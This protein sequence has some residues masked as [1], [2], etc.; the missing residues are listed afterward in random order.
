MGSLFERYRP[1]TFDDIVGQDTA[2]AMVKRVVSR[3]WGG[4]AFW[5]TGCSGVGKTSLARVIAAHGAC[6]FGIEEIDAQSLTPARLREIEGEMRFRVLGE[7]PGRAYIVNEAH[8][9]R[10]DTIRLLL[11]ILERLP[12]HCVWVFTTTKAGE[13][14]LFEDDETGD[15]APL[16]SRC[17]EVRL[18]DNDASRQAFAAR[19][20]EIAVAEGIDGLPVTVYAKAV[21]NSAGNFRR[22]LQRIESGG[23]KD[24]AIEGLEKE[25]SMYT[26]QSAAA[27]AGR[28]RVG[29]ALAAIKGG[30]K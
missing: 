11:V 16:L 9:L 3:S 6:E 23:F 12:E 5:V 4:R 21:A 2:V 28:A 13:V 7:K 19:A 27:V 30:G 29:A 20:K 17:I 22:V 10:K 14:K 1:K 25:L 24:D 18:V 26:G 8:G 15:A